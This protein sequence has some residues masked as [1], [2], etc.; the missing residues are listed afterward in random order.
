MS[1]ADRWIS[2]CAGGITAVLLAGPADASTPCAIQPV[3]QH[4][5]TAPVSAT[6]E[7]D[8][9]VAS[10]NIAGK[11]GISGALEDLSHQRDL[12]ILLLQE[13]GDETMDGAEFTARLADRLGYHSAYA[14]ADNFGSATQGL[15]ILSRAPLSDVRV[16]P[17]EYYKLRFR[18]RCRIALEA[19]L[20]T[21][22]GPVHVVNVHL[23]TR[24]NSNERVAQLAPILESLAGVDGAQIVGGDFN[25]M[26]IHWFHTMWPLP[27]LRHQADAVHAR[28]NA[29]G[30]HTPF[31]GDRATLKL[32]GLPIHL[33]WVYLK[34][35]EAVDWRVESVALT[36]HRGI[37]VRA[38]A[39]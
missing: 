20:T 33:D 38:V 12:D 7:E 11:P 34:R 39:Q 28:M 36:D 18:S 23:D 1:R 13:V 35:L 14:P 5:A 9:T 8:L 4:V 19:T 26:P 27:W 29:D 3:V 6:S 16:Y 37:W 21:P 25:T 24:I 31:N 30:F 15:A 32:L 17:L 2:V 10:V 22:T